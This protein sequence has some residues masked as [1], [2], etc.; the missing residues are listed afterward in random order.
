[1]D[2]IKREREERFK[3]SNVDMESWSVLCIMRIKA[4][5]VQGDLL[6]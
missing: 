6:G 4:D 2:K 1:M 3:E 5:H